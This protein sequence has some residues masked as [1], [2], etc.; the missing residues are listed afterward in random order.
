MHSY[1]APQSAHVYDT[2]EADDSP[3][4]LEPLDP[5]DRVQSID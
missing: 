5:N 3:P 4:P 1:P 2:D